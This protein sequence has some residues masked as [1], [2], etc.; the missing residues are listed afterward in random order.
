MVDKCVDS[1]LAI[2]QQ[3]CVKDVTIFDFIL[4]LLWQCMTLQDNVVRVLGSVQCV[5]RV[6]AVLSQCFESTRR[7]LLQCSESAI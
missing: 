4:K 3:G 2:L 7:M 6:P 1:V 5:V